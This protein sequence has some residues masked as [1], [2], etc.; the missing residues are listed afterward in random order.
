MP[1]KRS[2]KGTEAKSMVSELPL[3]GEMEEISPTPTPIRRGPVSSQEFVRLLNQAV[4]D[5]HAIFQS[6][7]R[8]QE[9]IATLRTQL[10]I[11]EELRLEKEA[12]EQVRRQKEVLEYEFATKRERLEK[13]LQERED[14]EKEK[15]KAQADG[16]V[17]K[18]K[19]E[20]E[21]QDRRLKLERED[22]H[23][24]KEQL[25][26]ERTTIVERFKTVEM[27]RA[28]L[29]ESLVQ[30]LNRDNAHRL[31]IEQLRHQREVDIVR[32][33][34]TL[35]QAHRAKYEQLLQEARQQNERL[36]EQLTVLSREALASAGN[37]AMASKLK[38][39]VGQLSTGSGG[40]SRS[41]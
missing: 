40:A 34:L 2:K 12:V 24:I 35:E 10:Q 37:A 14:E 6:R 39:V 16:Q 28:A 8:L 33:E 7:E 5:V 1:V 11:G 38:E 3:T 26:V 27:E 32:G 4:A 15:W 30:E 17:L 41:A 25:E 20:R 22:F 31:E 36:A 18:L 23:R 19:I 21:E 13:E 29:R 9:E